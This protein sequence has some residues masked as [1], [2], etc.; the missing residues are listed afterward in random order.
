MRSAAG[1]SLIVD[2]LNQK[3]TVPLWSPYRNP[4]KPLILKTTHKRDLNHNDP[5]PSIPHPMHGPIPNIG[6]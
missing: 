5:E 1:K 3:P 4:Y 2:N 6:S